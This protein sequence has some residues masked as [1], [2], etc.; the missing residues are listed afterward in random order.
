MVPSYLVAEL[1]VLEDTRRVLSAV[2][3]LAA[4]HSVVRRVAQVVVQPVDAI[5]EDGP[6]KVFDFSIARFTAV[7][8]RL[9]DEIPNL[10]YRQKPLEVR[11]LST[12]SVAGVDSFPGRH[13]IESALVARSPD[14]G[15]LAL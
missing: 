13:L 14:A 5:D 9:C 3:P 8:T 11:C 6:V 1:H 4:R 15:S 10:V 12:M 7:V 2:T